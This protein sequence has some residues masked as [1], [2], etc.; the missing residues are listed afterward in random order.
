MKTERA[1]KESFKGLGRNKTRTF[2]MML[3]IIIGIATLT[4]IVSAILGAKSN[5]MEKVAKFGLDQVAVFAGAGK[6]VG[7]PQDVPVTTLKIEDGEAI[8]SEVKNV[9]DVAPATRIKTSLASRTTSFSFS[10]LTE[11]PEFIILSLISKAIPF[12]SSSL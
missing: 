1:I 11:P 12:P 8:L 2:L 6:V 3:G 5:V 4:I 10:T 9:K 7:V